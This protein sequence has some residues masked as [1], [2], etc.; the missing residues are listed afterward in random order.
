M[1][2]TLYAGL[3]AILY[4]FL[5]AYVIRGRY[6]YQVGLGEGG[7]PALARRVRIHGNFVEYVPLALLLLY[8]VDYAQ[9]SP[10]IVHMLG[11]MLVIGRVLHA[12]GLSTSETVSFGRFAGMVLTLVMI[13]ACAILLL[14]K[15]LILRMNAL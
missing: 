13:A 3:L 9:Y 14:W 7:N 2:T 6:K 8:M 11:M 12:W 15:F 4:L 5:S 1:I 10:F